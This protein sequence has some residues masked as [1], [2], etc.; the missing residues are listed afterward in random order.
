MPSA[1]CLLVLDDLRLKMLPASCIPRWYHVLTLTV[2][3]FNQIHHSYY[4]FCPVINTNS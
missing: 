3:N 1:M 2:Q 4:S